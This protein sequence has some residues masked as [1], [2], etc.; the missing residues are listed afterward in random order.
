VF[1][2]PSASPNVSF[3]EQQEFKEKQRSV[4]ELVQQRPYRQVGEDHFGL[5]ALDRHV[6]LLIQFFEN[7]NLNELEM[8]RGK[9]CYLAKVSFLKERLRNHL[10]LC[11]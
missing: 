3:F 4:T 10:Q 11:F 8:A 6:H 7:G 2:I 1:P 5:P 9:K